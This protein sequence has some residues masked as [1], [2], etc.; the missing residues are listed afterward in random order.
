MTLSHGPLTFS[1]KNAFILCVMYWLV[2]TLFSFYFS[3]VSTLRKSAKETN[4]NYDD[5][6]ILRKLV[7]GNNEAYLRRIKNMISF[8]NIL[9]RIS[10]ITV[11][12]IVWTRKTL[13]FCQSLNNFV[14]KNKVFL[15]ILKIF[16]DP[17][18]LR[19]FSCVGE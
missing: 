5:S 6:E 15:S 9:F 16:F 18:F 7:K 13:G 14:Q 17:I 19:M 4:K 11:M 3:P 12:A 2:W 8:R 1:L 10:E